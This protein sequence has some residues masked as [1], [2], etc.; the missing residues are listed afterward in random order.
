MYYKQI[1]VLS[2]SVVSDSL[3]PHGL[4]CQAPLS[5]GILQARITEVGCQALLQRIVPTQGSNPGV[6]HCRQILYRLSH[7]RVQ[8]DRQMYQ[9]SDYPYL[10]IPGRHYPDTIKGV[11]SIEKNKNATLSTA[12][13]NCSMRENKL[14]TFI[15]DFS[16]LVNYFKLEIHLFYQVFIKPESI[17]NSYL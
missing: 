15:T 2:C 11:N 16:F 14:P 5:I 8:I 7:Q 17:R 13:K 1:C 12:L 4:C 10:L 6:P 9:F 3:Q